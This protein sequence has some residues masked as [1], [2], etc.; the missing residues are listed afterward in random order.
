MRLKIEFEVEIPDIEHT[1]EEL[2]EYCKEQKT[3]LEKVAKMVQNIF[4]ATDDKDKENKRK[5]KNQM[6]DLSQK[7]IDLFDGLKY[8]RLLL[9][10]SQA[11]NDAENNETN[12][13][14]KNNIKK[15]LT[16][17]LPTTNGLPTNNI[18]QSIP[19]FDKPT[20]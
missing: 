14:Q 3:F 5:R 13:I 17:L 1:E 9:L 6:F 8:I 20:T 11:N 16:S 19:P 2:E 4:I 15:N 10:N 12:N 18:L 7:L